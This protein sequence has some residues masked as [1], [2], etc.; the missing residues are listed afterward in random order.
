MTIHDGCC[1]VCGCEFNG[2]HPGPI[3]DE[4]ET[5][6]ISQELIDANILPYDLLV[7]AKERADRARAAQLSCGHIWNEFTPPK[8]LKKSS[9]GKRRGT[10]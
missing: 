7:A 8:R 6:W 5:L 3:F 2:V 10:H 4:E 1:S 9:S